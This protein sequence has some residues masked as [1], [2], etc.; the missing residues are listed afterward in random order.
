MPLDDSLSNN[1][2]VDELDLVTRKGGRRAWAVAIFV[3]LF[4]MMSYIDRQ[5]LAVVVT[6]MRLDL[7]ITD[8]QV[9]WLMGPAFFVVFNLALFPAAYAA[10]RWNRNSSENDS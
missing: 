8:V 1:S 5:A 10:D 6:D 3:A 4:G 9:G 7:G 2:L